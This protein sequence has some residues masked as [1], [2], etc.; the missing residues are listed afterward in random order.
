MKKQSFKKLDETEDQV[1]FKIQL[2]RDIPFTQGN[3]KLPVTKN[4]DHNNIIGEVDKIY[5][6]DGI[7]YADLNLNK[8]SLYDNFEILPFIAE[9]GG[10]VKKYHVEK[11][12]RVIDE[13]DLTEISICPK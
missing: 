9:I 12:I 6:E 8:S 13:I 11:D 10:V 5:E 3:R 2:D 7:M 1:I 4:F